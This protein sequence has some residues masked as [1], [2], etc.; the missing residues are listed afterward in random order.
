MSNS[1]TISSTSETKSLWMC[2][3]HNLNFRTTHCHKTQIS[4][5]F[6]FTLPPRQSP[7]ESVHNTPV[8]R[9]RSSLSSLSKS[10]LGLKVISVIS[11]LSIDQKILERSGHFFSKLEKRKEITGNRSHGRSNLG[12]SRISHPF[13]MM[14]CKDPPQ[15]KVR[16]STA[17]DCRESRASPAA[18]LLLHGERKA[19]VPR[20]RIRYV[21]F[22]WRMKT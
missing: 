1:K 22:A 19:K 5:D 4:R 2:A 9:E 3:N 21:R 18:M 7:F 8:T 6:Y 17:I 14:L 10:G 20:G 12:A 11:L 16:V 15:L 13:Y